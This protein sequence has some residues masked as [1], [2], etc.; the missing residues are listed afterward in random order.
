MPNNAPLRLNGAKFK[1]DKTGLVSVT[2]PWEVYTIKDCD[3]FVPEEDLNLP[4]TDRSASETEVGTWELLLTYEGLVEQPKAGDGTSI[5]VEF[6]G[7]MAQDPIKSHPTFDKLKE[8]YG[9]NESGNDKGFPEDMPE[10]NK[11]SQS[12]H[13]GDA[14]KKKKSSVYGVDSW[15][16]AEGVFRATYTL[17]AAPQGLL[18]NVGKAVATPR[19]WS[20]IGL[21]VPPGRDWLKV[22]PK[23]SVKGN[24]VRITEEYRLSGPNGVN[25]DIY[26]FRQVSRAGRGEGLSEPHDFS[27]FDAAF[28]S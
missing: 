26:N 1:R 24:A 2:I 14:A 27:S 21:Q 6:D 16:V 22:M 19:F 8:K 4:I 15:L 28:S 7:N 5:E 12:A 13:S 18:T 3:H 17:R 23:I 11:G 9:W 25:K 20:L 10:V